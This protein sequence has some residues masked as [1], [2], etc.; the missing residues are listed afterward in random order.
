MSKT[1]TR[2]KRP[3]N[4]SDAGKKCVIPPPILTGDG[5]DELWTEHSQRRL[6]C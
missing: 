2:A 6:T 4:I 1:P 3:E 5:E